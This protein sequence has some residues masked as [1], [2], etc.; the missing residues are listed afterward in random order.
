VRVLVVED[1]EDIRLLLRLSLGSEGVEIVGEVGDGESALDAATS[2]APDA[3]VLD[4]QM[5]GTDGLTAL[6][7]LRRRCPGAAVV[8]YS[9]TGRRAEAM[10]AGAS[11]YV[12]KTTSM[13]G[14][15]RA[16]RDVTS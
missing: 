13:E 6:P 8:V 10:A 1:D 11:A 12:E 3:V 16:L 7:L 5:P 9:A 15:V 14:V 4:L 2:T